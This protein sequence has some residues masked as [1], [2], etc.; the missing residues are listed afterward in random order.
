MAWKNCD[1]DCCR[2]EA[3]EIKRLET[4][5]EAL[6]QQICKFHDTN[7]L[8]ETVAELEQ[9]RNALEA[10]NRVMREL[11]EDAL[12]RLWVRDK[13]YYQRILDRCTWMMEEEQRQVPD[14]TTVLEALGVRVEA[15]K[16]LQYDWETRLN[17]RVVGNYH[18]RQD[19]EQ[20]IATLGET[21]AQLMR[22]ATDPL[23]ARIAA[24]TR[25]YQDY[26][27]IAGHCAEVYSHFSGGRI[28]KP[29]TLPSEVIAQAEAIQD[30]DFEEYCKEHLEVALEPIRER[31]REFTRAWNDTYDEHVSIGNELETWIEEAFKELP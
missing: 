17:G 31:L 1:C 24:L 22:Q 13:E 9:A 18:F 11:V 4:A 8:N 6:G 2:L 14:A 27:T 23:L 12:D 15:H 19:A 10:E 20:G 25:E 3:T 29:F 26:M 5:V 16:T 7:P 30:A 21:L 28:S